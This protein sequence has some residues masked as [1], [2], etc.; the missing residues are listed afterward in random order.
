MSI[1]KLFLTILTTLLLTSGAWAQRNTAEAAY[2]AAQMTLQ[3][4]Q[5]KAQMSQQMLQMAQQMGNYQ[6]MQLC[7]VELQ[8]H[9]QMYNG[10][11]QLLQNP[12]QFTSPQ[13]QQ[14]FLETVNEYNYRSATRDMRPY[15][16]IQG[17]LQQFVAHQAWKAGTPQGQAAHQASQAGMQ[18]NMAQMT[19]NH[20]NRMQTNYQIEAARNNAWANNQAVGDVRHSQNI[21]AINNEYQYVDPNTNQGYWVHMNNQN[22]AVQNADG[23]WTQLTPYHNY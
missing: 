21:H 7:Q 8:M 4:V 10:L 22:P 13:V 15:A 2:Q 11:T 14:R 12:Q 18:A 3:N 5:V 20:N 1:R 9:Q 23:S 6:E 17:R 19:A 16:Q